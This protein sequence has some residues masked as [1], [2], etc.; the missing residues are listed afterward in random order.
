MAQAISGS[1]CVLTKAATISGTVADR[2]YQIAPPT[3]NTPAVI[4][5]AFALQLAI[6]VPAGNRSAGVGLGAF[7]PGSVTSSP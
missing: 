1:S 6:W 7:V 5:S 4:S 2:A 3:R